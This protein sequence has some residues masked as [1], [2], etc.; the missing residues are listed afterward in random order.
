M[1]ELL[2][3]MTGYFIMTAAAIYGISFLLNYLTKNYRVSVLIA[4]MLNIIPVLVLRDYGY[5]IKIFLTILA[6]VV[7][8]KYGFKNERRGEIR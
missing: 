4:F 8:T 6:A 1:V 3:Y 2:G 7:I 5:G